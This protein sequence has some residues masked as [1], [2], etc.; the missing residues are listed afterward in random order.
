MNAREMAS[1]N[2]VNNALCDIVIFNQPY[3]VE[4]FPFSQANQ[5]LI[6]MFIGLL[7]LI[8]VRKHRGIML[9]CGEIGSYYIL[10][11]GG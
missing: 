1:D 8:T 3:A 10:K 9:S 2:R 7:V 5:E 6:S 11:L 4:P